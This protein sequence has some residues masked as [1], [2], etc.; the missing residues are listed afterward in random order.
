MIAKAQ[1]IEANGKPEYAVIPY[2][3]Y[4]R[5]VD[6]ASAMIAAGHGRPYTEAEEDAEDVRAIEEFERKL[7]AGEE[8]LLPAEMV[9]RL[10]EGENALLVWREHRG[11]TQ[12]QLAKAAGVG[13]TYISMIERGERQGTAA[14][15]RAIARVLKVQVDD[16]LAGEESPELGPELFQQADEYQGGK[17][18]QR[19]RR[20]SDAPLSRT[21][22][23]SGSARSGS[24]KRR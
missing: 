21:V 20:P 4:L 7:A 15:L 2:R 10:V 1:I 5:L 19:G 17:L 3:D 11:L 9:H 18:V 23:S 12:A 8:E 13:Q 6:L 16:L 14:K 22:A 24:T